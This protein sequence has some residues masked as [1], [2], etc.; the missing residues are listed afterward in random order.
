MVKNSPATWKTWVQSLG[1]ED[2]GGGHGNPFQYSYL[3]NPHGQGNLA[4]CSP[5]G[6]KESDM[7]EQ[8]SIAQQLVH[9]LPGL[10]YQDG[11][12]QSIT[13]LTLQHGM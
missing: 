8:Q 5:W 13:V 12:G 1:W 2:S 10:L 6:H 9:F 3:E 11:N 7:T 4:G